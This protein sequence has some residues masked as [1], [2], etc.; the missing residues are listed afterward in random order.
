MPQIL[1]EFV[2]VT[3]LRLCDTTFHIANPHGKIRFG[4]G[5]DQRSDGVSFFLFFPFRVCVNI[6]CAVLARQW[7]IEQKRDIV[8]KG[9]KKYVST[10]IIYIIQMFYGL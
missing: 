3:H 6:S 2:K 7:P 10:K 4:T 5:C 9:Q 8:Y 1:R